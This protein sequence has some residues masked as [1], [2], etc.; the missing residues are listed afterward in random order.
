MAAWFLEG[1]P[2]DAFSALSDDVEELLPLVVLV[3]PL[4][5]LGHVLG[6]SPSPVHDQEQVV[7]R[8]KLE[9]H[10]L[11]LVREGGREH[12]HPPEALARHLGVP[13]NLDNVFL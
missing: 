3:H 1:L 8:Q 4:E 6:D 12:H 10:L 7:V 9:G 13:D 5:L 11:V 2:D